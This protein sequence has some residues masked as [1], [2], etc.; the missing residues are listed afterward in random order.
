M[1][2]FEFKGKSRKQTSVN[3]E[4]NRRRTFFPYQMET[5]A[6]QTQ[7]LFSVSKSIYID[8]PLEWSSENRIQNE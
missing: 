8:L 2:R 4:T 6:T 3:I 5:I 7:T 1:Q